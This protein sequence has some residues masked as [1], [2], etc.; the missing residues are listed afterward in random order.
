M[1]VKTLESRIIEKADKET[2]KQIDK[3]ISDLSMHIDNDFYH[4][5]YVNAFMISGSN[6][7]VNIP[8]GGLIYSVIRDLLEKSLTGKNRD[9]EL[10]NFVDKVHK[11]QAA[12]EELGIYN[13][14]NNEA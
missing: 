14:D 6:Y 9:R 1:N 7:P 10:N 3:I 2:K 5:S 8:F 11:I 13:E 4:R 12:Y